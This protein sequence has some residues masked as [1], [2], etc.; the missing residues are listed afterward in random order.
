MSLTKY[1]NPKITERSTEDIER[2]QERFSPWPQ[3][4][5]TQTGSRTAARWAPGAAQWAGRS[6]G[7]RC[8]RTR[9][10]AAGRPGPADK[11]DVALG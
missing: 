7:A 3:R 8:V 4:P 2:G 10:S 1:E 11:V 9:R 6:P 5:A